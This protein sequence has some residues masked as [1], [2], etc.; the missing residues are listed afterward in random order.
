[1]S[2]T[3]KLEAWTAIHEERIGRPAPLNPAT[4][5]VLDGIRETS[6]MELP[7]EFE[8][9]LRYSNGIGSNWTPIGDYK[10]LP[11]AMFVDVRRELMAA[12]D[13]TIGWDRELLDIPGAAANSLRLFSANYFVA[14]VCEGPATGALWHWDAEQ[15]TWIARSLSELIERCIEFHY[16]GWIDWDLFGEGTG[17]WLSDRGGLGKPGPQGAVDGPLPYDLSIDRL[18][19][20]EWRWPLE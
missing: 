20:H 11:G 15:A 18:R 8:E 4:D 9:L 6:G 2:L 13:S 12:R 17:C 3:E 7:S 14:M 1:M 10:Y 5:E 19:R 16:N